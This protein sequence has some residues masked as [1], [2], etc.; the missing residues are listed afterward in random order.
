MQRWLECQ[1]CINSHQL[2]EL[3]LHLTKNNKRRKKHEASSWREGNFGAVATPPPKSMSEIFAIVWRKVF[4][5]SVEFQL[6]GDAVHARK[7]CCITVKVSHKFVIFN[8]KVHDCEWSVEC[9]QQ[10]SSSVVMRVSFAME[11]WRFFLD[12]SEKIVLKRRGISQS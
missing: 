7:L 6:S 5:I 4:L 3:F 1:Q 8:G 10:L 11:N 9:V 12:C 2:D